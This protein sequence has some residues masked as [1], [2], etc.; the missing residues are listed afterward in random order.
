MNYQSRIDLTLASHRQ[1]SLHRATIGVHAQ[2]SAVFALSLAYAT[3]RYHLF[4]G[5]AWADWPTY[6]VNKAFAVSALALIVAGLAPVLRHHR[7]MS[8]PH[9]RLAGGAII[10]HAMLSLLL[11]DPAYYPKFFDGDK[12]TLSAGLALLFGAI[13]ALL[14]VVSGQ[15]SAQWSFPKKLGWTGALA[16]IGGCHAALPGWATWLQPQQ[17]PA[18]MPPITLIAFLLGTAAG[19][20]AMTGVQ[21]KG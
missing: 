3:V 4:K 15:Q 18:L 7:R 16:F 2:A 21:R 13:A 14:F 10:M 19:A 20:L 6:T 12:L 5:V 11:L 8:G 17:W 9:L 1:P